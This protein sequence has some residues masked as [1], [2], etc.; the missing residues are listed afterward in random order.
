[1]GQFLELV[2]HKRSCGWT[3]KLFSM[4]SYSTRSVFDPSGKSVGAR[5]MDVCDG[6]SATADR[7]AT[8]EVGTR[9]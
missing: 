6:R 5:T 9:V 4:Y 2:Y 8:A 3:V 1:M 7:R